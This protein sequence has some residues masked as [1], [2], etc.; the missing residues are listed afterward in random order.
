[1]G[2]SLATEYAL[3]REYI[4]K[5]IVIASALVDN[6]EQERAKKVLSDLN[7]KVKLA[8]LLCCFAF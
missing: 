4:E 5:A 2:L 7:D 8:S 3:G 6:A 1:V